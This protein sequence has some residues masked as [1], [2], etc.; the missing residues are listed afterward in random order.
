PI[1]TVYVGGGTPSLLGARGLAALLAIERRLPGAGARERTVEVNPE[2]VDDALLAALT[3][4]GVSRVSIGAQ[5]LDPA[6]LAE[7][8]RVH[9][10]AAALRAIER[11]RARGLRVSVD[12]MLGWRGQGEAALARDIAR[13]VDAGAEHLSLYALTIEPGTPWV[14]LVR[15]GLRILPDDDQQGAL[16]EAAERAIEARGLTHYEVA[17]Y[18]L[19]GAEAR[20]NL[21]YW[22]WQD[23][24]GLGPSAHSARL[25]ASGATERRAN[26]R[27]L[28]AWLEASGAAGFRERLEP[29]AAAAEGLWVGLRRLTGLEIARYLERFP[30]TSRAWVDARVAGELARGN[31]EWIDGGARLR[32]APGRWLWHDSIGAALIEA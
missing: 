25:L 31:L 21:K 9:D 19:P 11:A 16:L 15:R 28:A 29:V 26:P 20:H 24:V 32:V 10:D 18:A 27:G 17:S 7:L 8:G 3:E 2:H 5:S 12:L 1:E 13:V 14:A 4:G 6:G 23:Y 30:H 22:T